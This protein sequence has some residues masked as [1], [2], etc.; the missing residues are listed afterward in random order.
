[1]QSD[2]G[3]GLD[4]HCPKEVAGRWFR[5]GLRPVVK[6]GIFSPASQPRLEAREKNFASGGG[7]GRLKISGRE[8]A[9]WGADAGQEF[10]TWPRTRCGELPICPILV[11][12]MAKRSRYNQVVPPRFLYRYRPLRDEF[13]SLQQMLRFDKWWFGSRT[14]FDDEEDMVFPGYDLDDSNLSRSAS[15]E[16]QRFMDNTG[17]LCLSSSATHPKLGELYAAR[18]RGVCI[19]LESDFI[20]DPDYGPFKVTY[21]DEAK[22]LWRP[23]QENSE[24]TFHLLRKKRHWSYQGEWRCILKWN[25]DEKPTVG[26]HPMLSKRALKGLIFGWDTT[27]DERLEVIGSLKDAGW[28]R[29]PALPEPLR[30]G[31][32]EARLVGGSIQLLEWRPPL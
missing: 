9:A 18:G 8:A 19:K 27:A 21:S 32:Q 1:M 20:V 26:N 3:C 13:S 4:F 17:V 16:T 25:V 22:P 6:E 14:K 30:L 5:F 7:V 24:P 28:W 11:Y 23:F 2:L 10:L 31:L 12:V 29:K 15:V